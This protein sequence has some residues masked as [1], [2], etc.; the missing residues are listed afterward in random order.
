MKN[1]EKELIEKYKKQ[2]S[3]YKIA[4]EEAL[5]KKVYKIYIYSTYLE[6]SIEVAI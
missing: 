2:L 3:I 4:L 6:K 1:D 5:Q